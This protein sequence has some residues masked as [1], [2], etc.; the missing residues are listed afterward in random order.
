MFLEAHRKL[1]IPIA[2]DNLWHLVMLD[3]HIKEQLCQVESCCD[4]FSWSR[5]HQFGESINYLKNG[6]HSVPFE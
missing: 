4:C 1:G 2:H 6:V 5:F 3:P